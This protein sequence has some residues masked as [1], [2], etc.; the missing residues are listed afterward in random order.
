VN[1][2][3]LIVDAIFDGLLDLRMHDVLRDSCSLVRL[4]INLPF[5][6]LSANYLLQ[7]NGPV[8]F[9]S[10]K[11]FELPG[12]AYESA[13]Y[14]EGTTFEGKDFSEFSWSSISN[15]KPLVYCSFGSQV[16]RYSGVEA[17]LRKV[18]AAAAIA[19]RFQF[20]VNAGFLWPKF[21]GFATE[22][23]LIC[24]RVPQIKVLERA[25]AMVLHGGFGSVKDCIYSQTPM[26]ILPQK[27]DQPSNA[28]RVQYHGLGLA[29]DPSHATVQSIADSIHTLTEERKF[30]RNLATMREI[31]VDCSSRQP[32]ARLLDRILSHEHF[33]AVD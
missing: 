27:W 6:P 9:L 26:L 10:P 14:T 28:T 1:A 2:S 7:E 3:L 5:N 18:I 24:P 8:V 20:V 21:Q 4:Y 25:C 29:A 15:A 12:Q 17:D 16:E 13:F 33:G 30:R 23:V 22:N 31:F 11:A 32:T 19:E